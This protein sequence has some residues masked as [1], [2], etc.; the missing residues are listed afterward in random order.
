MSLSFGLAAWRVGTARNSNSGFWALYEL[1]VREH[2]LEQP[3]AL[4]LV[5][6]ALR[7]RATPRQ[8]GSTG[9][10]LI[11]QTEKNASRSL[12]DTIRRNME[13]EIGAVGGFIGVQRSA[14]VQTYEDWPEQLISSGTPYYPLDFSIDKNWQSF[15]IT[16]LPSN[17]SVSVGF[18]RL[19][20][21]EQGSI[22]QYWKIKIEAKENCP[23]RRNLKDQNLQKSCC[24]HHTQI[25]PAKI[26][27]TTGIDEDACAMI[28]GKLLRQPFSKDDAGWYT[29]YLSKFRYR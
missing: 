1:F 26:S 4:K 3:S 14:D 12:M 21:L 15:T 27:F 18:H 19:G 23:V 17:E 24:T 2:I 6:L 8:G 29:A 28:K 20:F 25:T 22:S 13:R 9:S 11:R 16:R 10:Q 7:I 5:V